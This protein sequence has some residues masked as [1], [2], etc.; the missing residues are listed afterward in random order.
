MPYSLTPEGYVDYDGLE[1]AAA[2]FRPRMIIGG[3]SAYPREWDYK[4][5]RAIADQHEAWLLIDMAHV[6]GLVAANECAS[7][8]EYADIVTSTT[9]KT[10]RGPRSGLIFGRKQAKGIDL[11][12]AIN[13]SVFPG[14][15]G[16]YRA[17]CAF[18]LAFLRCLLS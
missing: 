7:P 8:F 11:E 18:G 1:R 15:Q 12:E 13:N 2:T 6:S 16:V 9:H 3:G 14:A 10:L 17:E 4:R 5:L